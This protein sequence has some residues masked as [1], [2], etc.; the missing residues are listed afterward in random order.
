MSAVTTLLVCSSEGKR[1]TDGHL[2]GFNNA[3]ICLSKSV[4][5]TLSSPFGSQSC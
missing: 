2:V 3:L 5:K 1:F 4:T